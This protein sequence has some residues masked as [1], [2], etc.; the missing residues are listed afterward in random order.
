[1]ENG[2][3]RPC[4][5]LRT[6]RIRNILI[7]ELL[8]VGRERQIVEVA[9]RPGPHLADDEGARDGSPAF[10][11]SQNRRPHFGRALPSVAII[12]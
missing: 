9:T 7:K 10:E 12:E 4:S 3:P 11:S 2:T 6:L 8:L 5:W 1:M